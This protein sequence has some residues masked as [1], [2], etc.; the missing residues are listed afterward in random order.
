VSYNHAI[1]GAGIKLLDGGIVRLFPVEPGRPTVIEGNG[2]E[3]GAHMTL[4]GGGIAAYRGS[5]I[6]GLGVALKDNRGI[7]AA[8]HALDSDVTL[9]RSTLDACGPLG[10]EP[11]HAECVEG[12]PCNRIEGNVGQSIVYASHANGGATTR[13]E[14]VDVRKN[15]ATG[16]GLLYLESTPTTLSNCVIADNYAQALV[17]WSNALVMDG[18]TIAGNLRM[19]SATPLD[20]LLAW[21]SP[22][23]TLA[24][25]I[26]WQPDEALLRRAPDSLSVTDVVGS[27]AAA[28]SSGTHSGVLQADPRF[29]DPA[30]GDYHL[31]R[32]SPGVEYSPVAGSSSVDLEGRSRCIALAATSHPCDIGAYE[33]QDRIFASGFDRGR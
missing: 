25:S 29:T 13:L 15:T 3:S 31:R 11:I 20:V 17:F 27:D 23:L 30:Q 6:C 2:D 4:S 16:Y 9:S 7:A 14:R 5:R 12:E 10:A 8:I 21:S 24:R 28:L 22:T 19:D 26:V 33:L 1:S 18:C 32:D